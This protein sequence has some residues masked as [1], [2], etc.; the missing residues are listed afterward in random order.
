MQY[1]ALRGIAATFFLM[2]ACLPATSAEVTWAELKPSVYGDRL[3]STDSVAVKL[4]APVRAQDDRQVPVSVQVKLPGSATVKAVTL[5]IDENPMPVSMS[6]TPAQKRGEIFVSANMRFNGPSPVRA[7]V[8]ADDGRLFMSEAYVKTIGLGACASPP[9]TAMDGADESLGKMALSTQAAPVSVAGLA[10]HGQTQRARLEIAHPNLTGLQMDQITLHYILPRYIDKIDVVQGAQ[11]L[12]T[13][14]AGISLS[15][16]P[17]I[18]FDYIANGASEMNV[19]A[20][21]TDDTVFTAKLA[22]SPGS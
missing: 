5:I 12:A 3:I 2:A 18:S 14:E 17:S 8:E 19:T 20:R 11:P 6:L 16:N 22:I 10:G 15:E 7:V 9:V 21:D 1:Q 4:D 13:I